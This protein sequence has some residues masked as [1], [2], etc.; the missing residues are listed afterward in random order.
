MLP[1]LHMTDPVFQVSENK[2][3]LGSH[4]SILIEDQS[5]SDNYKLLNLGDGKEKDNLYLVN[6]LH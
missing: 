4:D 5:A 6:K 3:V 1:S 2:I